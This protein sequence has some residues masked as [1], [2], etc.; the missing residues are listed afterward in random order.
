[1][2]NGWN[3]GIGG[4]LLVVMV[5]VTTSAA[6]PPAP[7]A[8]AAPV[9]LSAKAQQVLAA[10]CFSCHGPQAQLGGLRL[11]SAAAALKG[12]KTGLAVTPG[13]PEKSL[14]VKAISYD[15]KLKMPPAGKLSDAEIATLTQWVKQGASW[16]AAKPTATPG[17][18]AAKPKAGSLWA[19]TPLRA[20]KI[21]AV[22][23]KSWV[24]TPIDAF[25]LAE[26]ERRGMKPSP[27]ADRR[28]LIRRGYLDLVGLPPTPQEVDAF[29]ADRDANAWAKVVDRLLA[30]PHFGERLALH[31]L[32]QA[33]YADSDGYH[34]DT[35]RTQWGYR[36][37]VINAFNQDK[38]FDIF[39]V[40]Q[41][42]GDLLPNASVEQKVASAFN[43]SGPTTSEGGAIPEEVL[44]AYAV[45]RVNTTTSVWLGLTVQCAQ[46]HD[47][48]YDPISQRDYYSL[49][50]FFN[51][52]DE[53]DL[54]VASPE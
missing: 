36:D 8:K 1:M 24:K 31:W 18:E 17:K 27:Y 3:L 11:D 47:H 44:N 19:F 34:D 30:S 14:L 9:T 37:Y 28:T 41:I 48:K 4:G 5:G 46:C 39:T 50:A 25:I 12:G 2:R 45:D 13:H 20:P 22:K 16:T 6:A 26:L 10:R 38:P 51:D 40:E 29:V 15:G 42:A 35:D 23:A 43:R 52:D 33:R 49:Y 53:P 7:A 54:P 21:P 32:D